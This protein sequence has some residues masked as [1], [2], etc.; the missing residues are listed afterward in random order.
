MDAEQI[1]RMIF[2][3]SQAAAFCQEQSSIYL[4]K[5]HRTGTCVVLAHARKNGHPAATK[6][7]ESKSSYVASYLSQFDV[8]TVASWALEGDFNA[9]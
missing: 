4:L 8:A 6:A 7:S 2:D 1:E 5:K 9:F 3:G